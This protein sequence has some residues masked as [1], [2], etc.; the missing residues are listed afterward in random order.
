MYFVH[1]GEPR[2]IELQG[3]KIPRALEIE[4]FHKI[5]KFMFRSFSIKINNNGNVYERCQGKSNKFYS[6]FWAY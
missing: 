6:Y 3:L 2:Y 5:L 1:R 4:S